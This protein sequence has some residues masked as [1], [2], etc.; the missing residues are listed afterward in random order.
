VTGKIFG[1][2]IGFGLNDSADG[3]TVGVSVHEILAEQLP[4]DLERWLLVK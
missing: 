4:G 2:D 3:H 1:S